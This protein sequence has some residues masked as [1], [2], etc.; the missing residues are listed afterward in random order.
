VV[1][2]DGLLTLMENGVKKKTFNTGFTSHLLLNFSKSSRIYCFAHSAIQ[3]STLISVS[4]LDGKVCLCV[5]Y[6]L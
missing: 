2:C 6:K 4:I 1:S 3:V 5:E